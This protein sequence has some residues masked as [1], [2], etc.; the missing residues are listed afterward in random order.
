M[1]KYHQK[2]ALFVGKKRTKN[3]DGHN[4]VWLSNRHPNCEST[5]SWKLVLLR[6]FTCPVVKWLKQGLTPKNIFN[7]TFS[8]VVRMTIG[9]FFFYFIPVH[10]VFSP[11]LPGMSS[12]G[13]GVPNWLTG[14]WP[15]HTA[16]HELPKEAGLRVGSIRRL[17]TGV[18]LLSATRDAQY[19]PVGRMSIS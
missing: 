3:L 7:I 9:C 19:A 13:L 17:R 1:I 6:G 4:V 18:R 8:R 5:E 14:F 12:A 2:K 16:R 11:P 15:S 10:T